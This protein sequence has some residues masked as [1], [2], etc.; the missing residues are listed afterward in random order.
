LNLLSDPIDGAGRLKLPVDFP[1][2]TG[3]GKRESYGLNARLE[4]RRDAPLGLTLTYAFEGLSYENPSNLAL[5]D[6]FRQTLGAKFRANFSP[7]STGTFELRY[8][9]FDNDNLLQ[10][11]TETAA[12]QFGLLHTLKRFAFDV[13]RKGIPKVLF[14]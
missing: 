5:T 12:F 13:N 4:L 2:L 6:N 3:T 11:D 8:V 9:S 1:N 7:A 14:V 10:T